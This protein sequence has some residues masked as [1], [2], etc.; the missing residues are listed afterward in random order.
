MTQRDLASIRRAASVP[1]MADAARILDEALAL[2]ASERA[3][4][5][6]ELIAS[7]DG[8]DPDASAEWTDE[9]RARIDA[10]EAGS[11]TFES[12]DAMRARLSVSSKK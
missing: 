11:A 3:K 1:L 6:Q 9:I 4:L 10:V 12:W 8:E 5:A 2:E 7:L